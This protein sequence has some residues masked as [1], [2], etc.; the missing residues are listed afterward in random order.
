MKANAANNRGRM[1]D[2]DVSLTLR[3]WQS[4]RVPFAFDNFDNLK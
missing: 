3:R 2:F 1:Q 4:E